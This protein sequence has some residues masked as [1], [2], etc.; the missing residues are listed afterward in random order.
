[1]KKHRRI[2]VGVIWDRDRRHILIDQR[3]S[4]GDF[5]DFWEFPGGKIEPDEDVQSCIRREIQEELGI[6]I[7]VGD[8]LMA[9]DHEYETL[10]VTLFVHH[11]Y[12]IAGDPQPIQCAQIRWVPLSDLGSYTFPA[13]N[14]QIVE[15]LQRNSV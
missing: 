12:H 5:A 10:K 8:R 15:A 11:C 3:L 1:M 2:G 13:A 6:E 14:Y 7:E 9:L 4:E